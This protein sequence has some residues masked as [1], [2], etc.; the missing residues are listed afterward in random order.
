MTKQDVD[1]LVKL[2]ESLVDGD[3]STVG[4]LQD[5][6]QEL[7]INI[8]CPIQ[9][10]IYRHKM[11]GAYADLADCIS[12][13]RQ[14]IEEEEDHYHS[15]EVL[16]F[17]LGQPGEC[18]IL[19]LEWLRRG[20]KNRRGPGDVRYSPV[21]STTDFKEFLDILEPTVVPVKNVDL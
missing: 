14:M 18:C 8:Y 9:V 1:R 3:G 4:P 17:K 19:G 10:G 15:V 12:R 11:G 21:I 16:G 7:G 13:A 5:C 6:L 2:I 20:N